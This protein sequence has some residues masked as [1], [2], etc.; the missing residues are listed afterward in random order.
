MENTS[1]FCLNR[2]KTCFRAFLFDTRSVVSTAL[3]GIPLAPKALNTTSRTMITIIPRT[4]AKLRLENGTL[5]WTTT[6]SSVG[7][8][9][10]WIAVDEGRIRWAESSEPAIIRI[11]TPIVTRWNKR[12]KGTSPT[13]PFTFCP[14]DRKETLSEPNR[15]STNFPKLKNDATKRVLTTKR[16]FKLNLNCFSWSSW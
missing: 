7:P 5:F 4:T 14:S 9:M 10:G 11:V 15:G 8:G 12:P 6:K 3:I 2:N 1:I 16:P 13:G